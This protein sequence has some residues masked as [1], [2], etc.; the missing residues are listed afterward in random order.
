MTR[1]IP[2]FGS[3]VLVLLVSALV[4]ACSTSRTDQRIA[5]WKVETAAHLP[6][7]S[8]KR[9]AEDFFSS[10]GASLTCCMRQPPG[11]DYHFAVER[12]VGSMLWMEYDV[13]V[14][15]RFSAEGQVNEVKVE[16]WSPG[17]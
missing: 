7:G 8:P 5:Y 16:R 13:A 11:P 1:S 10:R 6:M 14:L 9:Q 12:H 15:V 4:S 3:A 17:P 2:W